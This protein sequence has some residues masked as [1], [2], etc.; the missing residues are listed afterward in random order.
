[1]AIG[2]AAAERGGVLEPFEFKLGPLGDRQ[3][4]IKV[5]YCGI[6][7]S[8]LSMLDNEWGSTQYPI[9][10]GHEIVGRI[11]TV[12]AKV[13]DLAPGQRVG[14]GWN[15]GSCMVCEWCL[16]GNHNLCA[17]ARPTIAGRYGGFADKV[18]ADAAWVI[19]LPDQLNAET[20][21]PL[22]C[23]GTT[24]FNA[25]EQFAVKPT[26]RV[27]V[28][29]IGGLGHLALRFLDAWGCE[30]TAFSTS[31]DKEA[32]ARE[33]GADHFVNA[34]DP[35][36]LRIVANSF[37]LI[38]STVPVPLD[39][40]AYVSALRPKGRLN[41]LG[42]VPQPVSLDIYTLLAG[43]KSVSASPTGS[44]ATTMKMLEFAVRHKIEPV[45][46]TFTFSQVN[47]A[48]EKLRTGKPKYR[49]VLKH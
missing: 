27:G 6:C 48:L 29:G 43:Q 11:D 33:F 25:L 37:D 17:S 35:N 30:V 32:N 26:D 15:A 41:I 19:P 39:W 8:D 40:N 9:V 10:P 47:D 22:F 42:A 12:G 38:L 18:R 31:A 7:R 20:A 46:E 13:I 34:R 1:M 36:A 3:V 14:L 2:Y 24:V 23:G 16:S 4:D 44:P 28:V 5:E 49:I 21:G 45:I